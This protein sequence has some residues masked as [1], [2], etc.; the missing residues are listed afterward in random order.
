MSDKFFLPRLLI[1]CGA[2]GIRHLQGLASSEQTTSPIYVVD[3]DSNNLSSSRINQYLS[4]QQS[5]L[6]HCYSCLDDLPISSFGLCIVATSSAP[7]LNILSELASIEIECLLLEKLLFPNL[8]I[9]EKSST[10]SLPANVFVNCPKRLYPYYNSLRSE[11]LSSDSHMCFHVAG[12]NDIASN[13]LHWI[14]L[15]YFLTNTIPDISDNFQTRIFSIRDSKRLGY[16]EFEGSIAIQTPAF[17]ATILSKLDSL[18]A[19][20]KFHAF[21]SDKACL[22]DETN[23]TFANFDTSQSLT[24]SDIDIPYQSQ[25]SSLYGSSSISSTYSLTRYDQSFLMHWLLFQSFT[26]ALVSSSGFSEEEVVS[27]FSFS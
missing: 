14:D 16:T 2:L 13:S 1:G 17:S 5:S 23:C 19:S 26:P 6:V 21:Y 20:E 3:P 27:R 7:R 22:I 10:I 8:S 9:L 24:V 4:P 11:I 25:L 15:F 12:I 18:T